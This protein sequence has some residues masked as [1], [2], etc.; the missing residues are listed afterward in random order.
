MWAEV[1]LRV[2]QANEPLLLSVAFVMASS[3]ASAF[4]GIIKSMSF[5]WHHLAIALICGVTTVLPVHYYVGS[6]VI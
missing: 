1:L 5:S 3:M 6:T 4:D 2:D